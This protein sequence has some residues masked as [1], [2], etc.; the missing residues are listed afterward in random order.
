MQYGQSCI[1]IELKVYLLRFCVYL[2]GIVIIKRFFCDQ[3][4]NT[5]LCRKSEL[6]E[7]CTPELICVLSICICM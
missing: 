6:K 3:I 5:T 7:K 1:Q 4:Q 2:H